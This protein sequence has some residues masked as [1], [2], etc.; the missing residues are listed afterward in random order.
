MRATTMD[1]AEAMRVL[2][3]A[4]SFVADGHCCVWAFTGNWKACLRTPTD[5]LLPHEELDAVPGFPTLR[6]AVKWALRNPDFWYG[7]RSSQDGPS[8]TEV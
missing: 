7:Q 8:A 2:A 5:G 4:A 3:E 1:D 6:E